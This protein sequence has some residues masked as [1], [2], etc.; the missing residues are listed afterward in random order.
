MPIPIV[1]AAAAGYVAKGIAM[2]VGEKVLMNTLERTMQGTLVDDLKSGKALNDVIQ[3]AK[4]MAMN[5]LD[6]A[7]EGVKSKVTL[8]IASKLGV[9]GQIAFSVATDAVFPS[10]KS[11]KISSVKMKV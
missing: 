9:G 4:D 1:A 7:W 10:E 6:T 5:P 2:Y 8:G 3:S 11:E